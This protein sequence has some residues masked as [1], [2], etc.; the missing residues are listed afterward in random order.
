[1]DPF[2]QIFS[3]PYHDTDAGQGGTVF[4]DVAPLR[5]T[6]PTSAVTTVMSSGSD[7][8]LEALDVTSPVPLPTPG[9]VQ[10]PA[11]PG[12]APGVVHFQVL[13][14]GGEPGAVLRAVNETAYNTTLMDDP[15][16]DVIE[17]DGAGE[18]SVIGSNGD[19]ICFTQFDLAGN[20]SLP[21]CVTAAVTGVP[22][23]AQGVEFSFRNA[24]SHPVH[25]RAV[26]SYGL[27][28]RT[29][30]KIEVF[31]LA[32]RLVETLVDRQE[33]AGSHD[34]TWNLTSAGRP[35]AS[36]IYFAKIQAGEHAARVRLVVMK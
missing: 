17:E 36:S 3:Y 10:M 23:A 8:P 22:T 25:G 19:Q 7:V 29:A 34:V 35:V 32:G 13:S 1:V 33:E 6:P 5:M 30:V 15:N 26:L 20:A 4:I 9:I 12:D 11:Q 21:T 31:D 28:S 18:I 24:G 27:P 14:G 2:S 16:E